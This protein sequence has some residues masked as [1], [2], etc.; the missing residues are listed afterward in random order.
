[1][2]IETMAWGSATEHR[3]Y[4]E[5]VELNARRQCRCGCKQRASHRGMA[6]G[7]CLTMGCE[8]SM[9]RWVASLSSY[10]RAMLTAR[11]GATG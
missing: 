2:T 4:I 7:V 9:R 1:M 8:L 3:R 10:R 11:T 6:N 5:P